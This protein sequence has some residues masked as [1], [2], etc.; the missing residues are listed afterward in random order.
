MVLLAWCWFLFSAALQA[1]AAVNGS[2]AADY[3][4][5]RPLLAAEL[6]RSAGAVQAEDLYKFLHQGVLGPAH[7]VVDTIR[8]RAWLQREW[9]E[10]GTLPVAGRPPLLLPLRPDGSLVRVD[11]VRL[12]ELT[13]DH[14]PGPAAAAG[15]QETV[16]E[17]FTA[18]AATWPRRPDDL[19]SLW[20]AVLADTTLWRDHLTGEALLALTRDVSEN[21]PA[22]HHSQAYRVRWRPHYRVVDRGRLP[23]AWRQFEETP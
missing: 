5:W 22:V 2:A 15:F 3:A 18:T 21:W 13:R 6:E 19:A 14:G 7:A 4:A 11:L 16:L 17:A 8:V 23:G 1:P 20:Q 9:T 12:Q 10:T